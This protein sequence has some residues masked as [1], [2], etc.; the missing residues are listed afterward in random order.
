MN[1]QL[2]LQMKHICKSFPGVQALDDVSFD[3]RHGE[4]HALVGE[5]GAGKSTL[6]K[7]LGGV[8]AQDQGQIHI[9]GA[10]ALIRQPSDALQKGISIIYQEFSLVPVTSVAENIFLGMEPGKGKLRFYI[11]KK[12]MFAE[13]QKLLDDIGKSNIRS[14]T[15]V[16]KL[17]VAQQ[18]IVE[19]VKA[20]NRRSEILV[21]D[22]PTAVLTQDETETLFEIVTQLKNNGTSIIYISH[23]LDEIFRICDRATVL[24]DGHKIDTVNVRDG[25]VSKDGLI[26]MMVGRDLGNLFQIPVRD[27]RGGICLKA[28]H[29]TR[30][31]EFADVS[32]TLKKGE[33]LG[34][35]GLVGAGRTEVMKAVF[36]LNKLDSGD[37]TFHGK[38]A[39]IANPQNAIRL[40][41]GF[42]P[43][44]RKREGLVLM[45]SMKTNVTQATMFKYSRMGFLK[46][47]RQLQAAREYI[48][49][50]NIKPPLPERNMKD[51]SGGNQQKVVIAKWLDNAPELLILD[52]PTRG[53]DVGAKQEIYTIIK[54]LADSGVSI[55]VVSSEMEEILGLCDRIIV[56]HEGRIR[57]EFSRS[58]AT[59]EKLLYA[60][61]GN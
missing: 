29:L 22:E 28:E 50:L 17:T 31:G 36:G 39:V 6:I 16:A 38:K 32:F 30:K 9:S 14:D 57:G 4:V 24:R 12:R 18:Q 47:G 42:V 23:R 33:I 54:N 35:S 37:I 58:E 59:Q 60:A 26:K 45:H 7:I 5:N 15:P 55:I 52:E 56:M 49:K 1:E 46:N 11:D 25:N 2:L 3:L 8:Y 27:S 61:S 20:L 40:K 41:L 19:I 51:F 21:M 13:A 53:V 48:G 43:E 34:F 44:D 10:E